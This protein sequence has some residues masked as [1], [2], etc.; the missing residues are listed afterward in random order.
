MAE[1]K[2]PFVMVGATFAVVAATSAI[3]ITSMVGL[4][5]P[6]A[7]RKTLLD[8]GYTQ[9]VH[10]GKAG[11]TSCD[12]NSTYRDAFNAINPQNRP[13][14]V[15]VCRTMVGQTSSIRIANS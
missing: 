12:E 15:V 7:G 5:D 9:P 13:V 2:F 8:A 1:R 10:Q 11:L 6:E 3:G 14:K 4:S